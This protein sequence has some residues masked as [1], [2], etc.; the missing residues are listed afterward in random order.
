MIELAGSRLIRKLENFTDLSED[1]KRTLRDA[2]GA[3]RA[4]GAHETLVS[5][6]D[7]PQGVHIILS[8]FA[9]R[10]KTLTDGRRQIVGY[11]IPGDMCDIRVFL[12]RRMDHTIATLAP[13]KVAH[14]PAGMLLA[15]MDRSARLNR[16][17]WWSTLVDEAIS[18][19]WLV[20]VGQRTALE[21]MAHLFCEMHARFHA[22]GL[23]DGTRF[24]LPVTQSE[25]ADTLALS[26][27][28]INRTLQELRRQGLVSMN[29][30]TLE[31]HD[32]TALQTVAVF[33]AAY[34]HLDAQR[35]FLPGDSR[36]K[37]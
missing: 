7:P 18:R 24:E 20:N 19:E 37:F 32:L 10:Y 2:I 31:I 25:L 34:L 17:L 13:T 14:M 33:D 4:Y 29:G 28:H 5:D 8:G 27:V 36:V 9:C 6:A 30:K 12:L 26:T 23:T 11:F 22:I 15:L 16:A 1:D 35:R 21:R 3:T